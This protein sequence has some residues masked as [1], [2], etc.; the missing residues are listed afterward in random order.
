MLSADECPLS[1]DAVWAD[2]G[3]AEFLPAPLRATSESLA[4]R[5]PLDALVLAAEL[6]TLLS[7]V[8]ELGTLARGSGEF[9][10]SSCGRLQFGRGW[11]H[12]LWPNGA[13][14]QIVGDDAR[15]L[16]SGVCA[17]VQPLSGFAEL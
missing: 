11:V 10:G 14:L 9:C 12:L 5:G 17:T 13:E 6:P 3:H 16:Q 2:P 4:I 15:V 7:P 1:A 8:H